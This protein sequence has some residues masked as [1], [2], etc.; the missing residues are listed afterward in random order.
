M[1]LAP[2][3]QVIE[4]LSGISETVEID[5]PDH[6]GEVD[7]VAF[8]QLIN[9]TIQVIEVFE[10]EDVFHGTLQ[11]ANAAEISLFPKQKRPH[12]TVTV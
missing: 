8:Q 12:F 5:D 7:V 11:N 6:F 9:A 2:F 1:S 10:E 4:Y 3:A